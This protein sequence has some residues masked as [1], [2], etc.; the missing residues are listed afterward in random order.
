MGKGNQTQDKKLW[1]NAY[2][3]RSGCGYLNHWTIL[4]VKHDKNSL[5]KSTVIFHIVS[6][7][8]H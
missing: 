8:I 2:P 7:Y 1:I 6:F 3:T 4:A 5:I